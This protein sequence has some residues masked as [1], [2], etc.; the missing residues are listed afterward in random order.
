MRQAARSKGNKTQVSGVTSVPAPVGGL[1][2]RDSLAEM[3]PSDAVVMENFFPATTEVVLRKGYS[4]YV[5]GFSGQV[6]TLM[7]YSST[8]EKMFAI[9]GGSVYDASTAGTV[10]SAVLTGLTNS[11]WQYCNI[12]TPGGQFLSMANGIDG[13]RLYDGTSWTTPTI[14]GVTP[15]NLNSPILFKNR[16]Y[17]IE[18]GTLK[19]WYLPVLSIAGAASAIDMS[20]VAKL[21]G[22]IVAHETWTMDAGY[23]VDDYYVAV[24]NHGEIIVYQGTDPSSASTWA[25]KGVWRLGA[26]VGARC[27]QKLGGDILIIC[28]DGLMPLGAA[29][30]SSRVNPRVALTDKIQW[31]ISEDISTY[32]GN[33]GWQSF[34]YPAENQLWLNVPTSTGSGQYQYAMNTVSSSWGKYIGFNANCL[35]LFNEQAFMGA[36]GAVCKVWTGN[37]DNGATIRGRALQAFSNYGSPGQLKR[38]TMSRPIFRA[39]GAPSVK[40]GMNLDFNLNVPVSDLNFSTSAYGQWDS[41]VWDLSVW[42]D[43]AYSIYQDWQGVQGVGYYGAPQV[44]AAT[45]GVDVRWVSTDVVF[46]KG[47]IL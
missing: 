38:F 39:T 46:E 47:Q 1:N 45:N 41:G 35:Q 31:S 3:P 43:T 40:G 26:P 32:G 7:V 16:Q 27:L 9:C 13:P 36:N 14:T 17:F 8:V 15:T 18:K 10:G 42:G 28:Q 29:L 5:T 34:Y 23:G 25:L 44:Y 30:Q 37:N 6:E 11:R 19:T 33:F 20:S 21:G 22:Y 4:N 24:T 12:A 2:S